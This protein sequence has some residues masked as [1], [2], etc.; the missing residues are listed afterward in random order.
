MYIYTY[1]YT[2]IY[3]VWRDSLHPLSRQCL[4]KDTH[5]TQLLKRQCWAGALPTIDSA[6][7]ETTSGGGDISSVPLNPCNNKKEKRK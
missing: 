2:Y 7:I 4:F 6:P 1:I 3:A 5:H